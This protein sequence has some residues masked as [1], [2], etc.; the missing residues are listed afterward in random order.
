MRAR[1]AVSALFA[2]S[3]LAPIAPVV[4]AQGG[5]HRAERV[6]EL[7]ARGDAYLAAGDR[8]SAIGYY[9]DALA[10]D[11]S[12]GPSYA[13]LG[14]IHLDRGA[15]ADARASFEAGVRRAPEHPPLWLGLSETLERMGSPGDAAVALRE[16]VQRTPR[17]PAAWRARAELAR[18][19]GAWSEAL[20]SYRA[21]LALREEGATVEDATL[22]EAERSVVALRFLVG[23]LDPVRRAGSAS[24]VRRALAR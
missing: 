16:L 24:P 10:I 23:T 11:P 8:G 5:A 14:R 20:G 2:A 18:R 12:D 13:A 17:D 15:L 9:R 6:A 22:E 19:R 3:C 21:I 7:R 4:S 1:L